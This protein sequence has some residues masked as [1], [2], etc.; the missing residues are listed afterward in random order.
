MTFAVQAYDKVGIGNTPDDKAKYLASNS[1]GSTWSSPLT[2][3]T[4]P[5]PSVS[6]TGAS[7]NKSATSIVVGS[8]EQLTATVTPENATNK[9]VTWSSNSEG[10][11]TVSETGLVKAVKAGKSTITVTT[12]DGNKTATC[13]VTVTNPVVSV[14]GVAL[15]KNA[16]SIAVGATEQL[17]ATVTP[18]N[19]TDKT[20]TW[21]SSATDIAT[22]STTGLVTAVKAG[23]AN[24]VAT[25]KDGSKTATCAVTVTA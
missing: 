1:T 10:V 21:S 2:K 4:V 8:S 19:A 16:S 20:I 3:V 14:T 22:V 25:T 13:E 24:I 23:T 15:N 7:L 9:T 5:E 18:D 12:K 11:A 6:V 17:T